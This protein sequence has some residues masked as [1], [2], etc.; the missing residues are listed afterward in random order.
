MGVGLKEAEWLLRERESGLELVPSR[1]SGLELLANPMVVEQFEYLVGDM[2]QVTRHRTTY[3]P[4]AIHEFGNVGT[5]LGRRRVRGLQA[6]S[7]V[8]TP[9]AAT[10]CPAT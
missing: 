3:T 10:L 5:W 6:I 9:D 8:A 4:D 7:A 2:V 1:Q